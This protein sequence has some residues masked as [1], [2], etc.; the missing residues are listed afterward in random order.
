M[1]KFLV[2]LD[3][4]KYQFEGKQAPTEQEARDAIAPTQPEQ[5][6]TQ[7]TPGQQAQIDAMSKMSSSKPSAN[8]QSSGS[9]ISDISGDLVRGALNSAAGTVDKINGV[10]K[11]INNVTHIDLGTEGLSHVSDAIR[12]NAEAQPKSEN[13]ALSAVSQFVGSVPDAILEFAG[14]GGPVGFIARSAGLSA[15]DEYNKSQT[16]AS[17]VKGGIVGGTVGLAL[18]KIPGALDKTAQLAKQWGETAGKEY[19]K[20]VTGATESEAKDFIKNINE[21]NLK[22]KTD[23]ESFVDT[24]AKFN[25]DINTLKE[26][27]K[28]IVEQK[29]QELDNQYK[30]VEDASKK[31]VTDASRAKDDALLNASE[32]RRI[33]AITLANSTSKNI[34][35]LADASANRLAN[36]VENTTGAVAKAKNSL[37][38]NMVALFSKTQNKLSAMEEGL[39]KDVATAHASLEKYG[40]DFIP[41]SILQEQLDAAIQRNMGSKLYFQGAGQLLPTNALRGEKGVVNGI[42]AINNLRHSLINEFE[43]TG[44]TS[45]AV[46]EALVGRN[47]TIDKL[48]KNGFE[49]TTL[50]P[51]MAAILA[52]IRSS[53]RITRS[54]RDEAGR[55][56]PGLYAKYPTQLRHLK[57]LA[58]AN[59]EYATKI[60]DLNKSLSLYKDNIGGE[61]S[62]NPKKVFDAIERNDRPYLSAIEQADKIL[63]EADKMFPKVKGMYEDF[64]KLESNEKVSLESLQKSITDRRKQIADKLEGIQKQQLL[65]Q[66]RQL[67]EL[68]NNSRYKQQDLAKAEQVKLEQLHEQQ[69]NV[70]ETIKMQKSN[71][72]AQLQESVDTRLRFLHIQEKSRG[73]RAN[74][75]GKMRIVQN[76]GEYHAV[77]GLMTGNPVSVIQGLLI[78]K[79]TSPIQVSRM[80]KDAINAPE[81]VGKAKEIAKN[82]ILKSLVATK[83]SGR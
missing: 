7:Y 18:E 34:V 57:P 13:P 3:G 60:D 33:D 9:L 15:A 1:P 29:K 2:E 56:L 17:L 49:G 53:L 24:K 71:E 48:I 67:S 65:D 21:I 78:N 16:A 76:V 74:A 51:K 42:N 72:L 43:E 40:N 25:E 52:D 61:Q 36:A 23:L 69:K 30:S 64:R 12:Q 62:I 55:L 46:H 32:S 79:A 31:L 47:G 44:Q 5:A 50:T 37:M 4:Q 80:I 70:L 38:D 58:D 28:N 63:P 83:A 19:W 54:S 27:N 82:K 8:S 68:R 75:S 39:S 11:L 81:T 41:T 77:S 6:Q 35:Q 22:P 45:L 10:A 59:L 14:T 66:N 26:S 20:S 73:A